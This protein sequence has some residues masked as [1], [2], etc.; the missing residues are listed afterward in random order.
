MAVDI[1]LDA[2]RESESK[3]NTARETQIIA[4]PPFGSRPS[5]D[6]KQRLPVSRTRVLLGITLLIIGL[7]VGFSAPVF[8]TAKLWLGGIGLLLIIPSFWIL[9]LH[10]LRFDR[11]RDPRNLYAHKRI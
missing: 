5:F 2:M 3:Q 10:R 9:G 4:Q 6:P 8:P 7:A 11:T 1:S